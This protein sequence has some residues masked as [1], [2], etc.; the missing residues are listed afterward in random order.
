MAFF[1]F[2]HECSSWDLSQLPWDLS[3]GMCGGERC[4]GRSVVLCPGEGQG[5]IKGMVSM[6]ST[7]WWLASLGVYICCA[8]MSCPG[9]CG[10]H[11]S[12]SF[13]NLGWNMGLAQGELPP[14]LHSPQLSPSTWCHAMSGAEIRW[15]QGSDWSWQ[16]ISSSE[17]GQVR[18]WGR[19]G[20]G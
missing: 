18:A 6:R 13:K 15:L 9:S 20:C 14:A 16:Q 5:S 10:A 8:W 2:E 4:G 12:N 7:G 1:I 17:P 11:N 3:V 19:A